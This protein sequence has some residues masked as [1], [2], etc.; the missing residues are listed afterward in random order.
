M[1]S[2]A[3]EHT[4]SAHIV[5]PLW[6]PQTFYMLFRGLKQNALSKKHFFCNLFYVQLCTDWTIA[7]DAISK[8]AFLNLNVF[9]LLFPVPGQETSTNQLAGIDPGTLEQLESL[10]VNQAIAENKQPVSWDN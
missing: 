4:S 9:R 5:P 3:A 10:D 8:I 6:R 1:V 7:H 2:E